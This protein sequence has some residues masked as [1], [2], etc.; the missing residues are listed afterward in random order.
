MTSSFLASNAWLL[1]CVGGGLPATPAHA[2]APFVGGSRGGGTDPLTGM[3]VRGCGQCRACAVGC[4][5]CGDPHDRLEAWNVCLELVGTSC[6]PP[7]RRPWVRGI[8]TA[9]A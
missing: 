8:A 9:W 3:V 2:R 4:W 1:E 7:T 5:R 6:G